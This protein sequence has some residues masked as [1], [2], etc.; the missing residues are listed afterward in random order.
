M[1]TLLLSTGLAT[2]LLAALHLFS[3][4][5]RLLKGVPRAW[6]L[7][8]GGGIAVAFVFLRL[9]PSVGQAQQTL[10]RAASGTW[11]SDLP[12]H[13]YAAALLSLTAF[14][15]VERLARSPQQA[16]HDRPGPAVFWVHILTFAAMNVL[17]GYLIYGHREKGLVPLGLF[18]VAMLLKFV[19]NDHSL[20]DIHRTGYDRIG[21]WILAGSVVAGWAMGYLWTVPQV[22]PALL[23][24]VLAGA[25]L[26]NVLKEELPAERQS[27]YSGFLAGCLSY[28]SLLLVLESATSN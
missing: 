16:R 2:M 21:R 23:Q 3:N 26:L 7:S 19:I 8:I 5:L 10:N 24:A 27:R 11:L 17:I 22:A 1:N 13:A 6:F 14:Y 20:H 15:G 9:L 28:G 4:V 25:V 12:Q 18:T